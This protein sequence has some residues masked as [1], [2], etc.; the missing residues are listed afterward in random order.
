MKVIVEL[1]PRNQSKEGEALDTNPGNAILHE[2]VDETFELRFVV[3]AFAFTG[4]SNAVVRCISGLVNPA[5][6]EKLKSK[7]DPKSQVAYVLGSSVLSSFCSEDDQDFRMAASFTK[8]ALRFVEFISPGTLSDE[9][10]NCVINSKAPVYSVF[11][12]A[13]SNH[14]GLSG[15]YG[16][17]PLDFPV[18][19]PIIQGNSSV[20]HDSLK[21]YAGVSQDSVN[22][23][24]IKKRHK[25]AT[26]ADSLVGFMLKSQFDDAVFTAVYKGEEKEP[27]FPVDADIIMECPMLAFK[28]AVD[29]IGDRTRALENFA[30]VKPSEIQ[31]S[32]VSDTLAQDYDVDDNKL[33]HKTSGHEIP[34]DK[35]V[36]VIVKI[37]LKLVY[38]HRKKSSTAMF[39]PSSAVWIK[40]I[41]PAS[42]VNKNT[43]VITKGTKP[44]L[45][46][47]ASND[48]K[49]QQAERDD[50]ARQD[51]KRMPSSSNDVDDRDLERGDDV[52]DDPAKQTETLL[53]RPPSPSSSS[54]SFQN[55][56]MDDSI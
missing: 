11:L 46:T 43:G 35:Q 2:V 40:D 53:V 33:T 23:T 48:R 24:I 10:K 7:V 8:G 26:R 30:K 6:M 1:I 38:V 55:P 31:F 45:G 16:K 3:P 54:S 5:V 18:P 42:A 29:I 44:F 51:K 37:N 50:K 19:I 49:K 41:W 34:S 52:F 27:E 20:W 22:N 39:S 9:I 36:V 28:R 25:A 47:I 15:Y 13:S 56:L 14:E 32:L 12:P 17:A 4:A 21:M